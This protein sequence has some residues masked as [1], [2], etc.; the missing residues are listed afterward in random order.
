VI[1]NEA[2]VQR[3]WP[4]QDALGK[5][6]TIAGSKRGPVE[7]VGV[8]RNAT[9]YIYQKGT[10][11]FFYL[12]LLQNP[13]PGGMVLHVRSKRDPM[14]M[15]PPVR[16]ALD[17][18]GHNVILGEVRPLSDFMNDSLLMLRVVSTLT[19]LFGLLALT[20]AVVGVFSVINYSTSRRTREI[21][22]RIALG[23]Q[24]ADI[25]RMILKEAMFIV[26]AGVIAG[27]LMAFVT[28][29]LISSLMFDNSGT[30]L[31]V[32]VVVAL[33]LIAIAILACFIPAYKATKVDP[34]DALRCE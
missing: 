2:M 30:D 19:A 11:P 33:V 23:A 4:G 9:A 31:P 20:L 13:L 26:V 5:R 28:G 1:V 27:L 16:N 8:V 22:I 6:I 15:L 18:L 17:S 24:R 10:M 25:L 14:A 21:G 29:R 3:Y 32:Y 12:P 7:I 34:S